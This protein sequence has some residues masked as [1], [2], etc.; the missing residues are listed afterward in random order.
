MEKVIYY[1]L[2][3]STNDADYVFKTTDLN[4]VKLT[5]VIYKSDV[6]KQIVIRDIDITVNQTG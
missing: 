1:N 3:I 4:S 6:E 5:G 2:V